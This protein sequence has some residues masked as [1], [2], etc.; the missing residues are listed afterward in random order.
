MV[1]TSNHNIISRIK[2]ASPFCPNIAATPDGSQVWFTLKDT[3]RVQVFN[4]RPP[5]QPLAMLETGPL[6]NHANFALAPSG[7]QLAYV[8]VGGQRAVKVF[9]T[10]TDGTAP[11]L[12]TTIDNVG[13]NPHGLWPSGDGSR[14]YAGLQLGNAVAVID[15][16][17]NKVLQRVDVGGQAPM[18]LMYVPQAIPAAAAA[19]AAAVNPEA[20]LVPAA[21]ARKAAKALHVGML[22]VA[23]TTG[24]NTHKED[25]ATA[26]VT[27]V[28]VNNQGYTDS[29]EAAVTGL[30]PGQMYVLGL[31][32][33][34]DG[35][36]GDIEP[37]ASFV[38]GKDGA[39][40]V[41]VLGPFRSM[42]LGRSHKT[43]G[44]GTIKQA[45]FLVI[46]RLEGSGDDS[47]VGG[48][49]QVQQGDM[50]V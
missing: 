47:R 44:S 29:L 23:A 3:G 11:K 39:A 40:N 2:Q 48:L 25:K 42:L 17:T 20:N 13:D 16:A 46:A 34:K 5:F 10:P 49:V 22:P 4:R 6:T 45:R 18:A 24:S 38:G 50:V 7:A 9:S 37:L 12:L 43:A 31:A 30:V 32:D 26:V 27:S 28:A 15:T 41:A 21:V 1:D 35:S 8:T 19:G 14:M 36:S 33:S